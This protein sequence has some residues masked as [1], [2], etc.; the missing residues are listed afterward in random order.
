MIG[1]LILFFSRLDTLTIICY[2]S[3]YA[4]PDNIGF[5]RKPHP[6]CHCGRRRHSTS[7]SSCTCYTEISKLFD[8]GLAKELK[9]RYLKA[10]PQHDPHEDITTYKL[11]ARS[12]SRRYMSPE[13]A[14]SLPYNEK[15]DVYSL[16]VVLY[17]VA[18]L[19]TPFEG[20]SLCRHEDEVLSSGDRPDVHIPSMKRSLMKIKMSD[21]SSY[22]DWKG[23]GDVKRRTK[24]LALRTKCVWTKELRCLIEECWH[25]DLRCRP[26]MRE[27]V[28]R[29]DRCIQDLTR[30]HQ[31]SEKKTVMVRKLSTSSGRKSMGQETER[32]SSEDDTH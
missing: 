19:V 28:G 2:L 14:F 30:S 1:W 17:Q 24:H 4:Q 16:G 22:D 25:A 27:V 7:S 9:P 32:L 5:Y 8:F 31:N 3:P 23:E 20:Y 15:A 13:V 29:L 11:T 12:G 21:I 10:H 18:S 6:H 26:S